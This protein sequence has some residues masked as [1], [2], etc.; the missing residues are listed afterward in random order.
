MTDELKQWSEDK[1]YDHAKAEMIEVLQE[2]RQEISHITD[3]EVVRDG[4]Y[5]REFEVIKI[6]DKYISK[7]MGKQ[8]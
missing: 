8:A 1:A 3:M 5:I 4:L 7:Y 6:I 2:I